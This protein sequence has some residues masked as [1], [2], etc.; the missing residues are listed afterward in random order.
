[1]AITSALYS[2]ASVRTSSESGVG[3]SSSSASTHKAVPGP[4]TPA[5]IRA[6]CSARITAAASPVA[7]RPICTIDAS[8]AYAA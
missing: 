6:R 1:M 2:L 3:S 7:S 4:E 8:T 5:P